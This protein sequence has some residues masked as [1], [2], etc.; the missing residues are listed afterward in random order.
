MKHPSVTWLGAIVLGLVLGIF[1]TWPQALHMGTAI[2]RHHDP[3]FS[4]WRLTWIAHALATS[5]GQLFD[6]NI[7]YPATET[8]AYSDATLLEGVIAAPFLWLHLSPV[9]VYNV[10]LLTGFAGSAVAMSG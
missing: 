10:L 6:A 9:L 8:L 3:Y 1:V 7:F 5:P 2:F 4:I